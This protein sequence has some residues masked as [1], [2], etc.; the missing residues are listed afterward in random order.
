MNKQT[1]VLS[2]VALVLALLYVAYFT[3]WLKHK[4][5]QIHWTASR[6]AANSVSFYLNPPSKL[7][8]VEVVTTEEAKTNKFPHA[9]W[10][11]VA[12]TTPVVVSNFTYG[13]AI[14]GMKP[15]IP[16]AVAEPLEPGTDYSLLVES[17]EGLKG[18]KSFFVH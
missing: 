5:I 13:A 14:P 9:L 17:G 10:H 15:K 7:T 2:S 12:G 8:S 18:E 4:D 6:A 16:T 11:V 3:D 1:V